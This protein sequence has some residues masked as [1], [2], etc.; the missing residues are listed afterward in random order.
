MKRQNKNIGQVFLH[1]ENIIRKII[2]FSNIE[3]TETILEIGCGKGILS[4]AL[5]E[6]ASSLTIIEVD[7][8]FLNYTKSLLNTFSHIAYIESD[9]RK[10]HLKELFSEPVRVIA[11]IPY[12]ISTNIIEFIIQER[13]LIQDA[14]LMV[15]REYANRLWAQPGSKTYGS[16]SLF[17]Q[18]YLDISPCFEVSRNSFFPVP[19]VDSTVIYLS[20]RETPLFNVDEPLFF[21]LIHAAF[22]GRRKTLLKAHFS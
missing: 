4:K 7:T 16:L 1:D 22:W 19:K 15:Q 10:I 2:H 5:A 17:A 13:P 21:K 12:H 9:I 20:P 3:S 6:T 14:T 18:F 11:N 8:Y